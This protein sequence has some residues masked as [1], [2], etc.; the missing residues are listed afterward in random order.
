MTYLLDT[1]AC[2]ALVNGSPPLPRPRLEHAIKHG[3]SVAVPV[4]AAFEL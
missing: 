3:D 2:I 1:N 4:V